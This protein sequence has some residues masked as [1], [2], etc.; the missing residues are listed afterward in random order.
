MK[1]FNIDFSDQLESSTE[2]IMCHADGSISY[3]FCDD[4]ERVPSIG[5][6][7]SK[8]NREKRK[9]LIQLLKKSKRYKIVI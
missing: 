4:D 1:K 8:E 5:D 3:G 9:E 2:N 6:F 7:F